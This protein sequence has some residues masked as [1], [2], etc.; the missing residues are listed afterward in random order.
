MA[1]LRSAFKYSGGARA[2]DP[3]WRVV[4]AL[5]P[6]R[7]VEAWVMLA[8]AAGLAAALAAEVPAIARA[9]IAFGL[10][11]AAIRAARRQ[12]WREGPGAVRRLAADLAGRI[13]VEG[14]DGRV[15]TGRLA[16]DSFVAPWLTI[17]RWRPDGCRLAR[18]VLVV[19]DA[20]DP[21]QFRRLRILL[22][23]R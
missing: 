4:I 19:P 22:R 20:V 23:W 21:A 8:A 5:G 18:T 6:S 12:A 13:E 15:V 3:A 10:A 17:V 16:D 7:R 1:A 14:A 9:A 11:V 2:C